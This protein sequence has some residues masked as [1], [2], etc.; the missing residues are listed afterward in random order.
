MKKL[1]Q[2]FKLKDLRMKIIAVALLLAASRVF[3]HI[4]I[5]GI[6]TAQLKEFFQQ[7]QLFGLL[8]I[9]AGG[10]L[11]NVS[12]AML[13]LAPYITASIIIQLLTI[14]IP[15]LQ[16][17]SKEGGE[18]GRA[19]I[20][21]YTRFL[22]IPLAVL[23]AF[24][25][26][27]LFSRGGGG[28][29]IIGVL[30]PFEWLLTLLSVTAG[31]MILM[32]LGEMITEYNIGNGISLLIFAGIVAQLPQFLSSA[33]LSFDSTQAPT[34]IGFGVIALL[35]I[36]G[37]VMITEATRNIPVSYAKRIRGNKLYGGV[38]THL[39]L[40][41]NTAG[42]IPIIFAISVLLFPGIVANFFVQANNAMI[43]GIAQKVV[44][45]FNNQTFY[46]A[47]YF[48]LVVLFTFFYTAVVFN[49]DE[50][51][52]N[53]QRQGGFV[54]GLRPGS[55]TADFLT[56]VLNRITLAGAVFLGLIAVLPFLFQAFTGSGNLVIGG[57]SLLIVVA[58]VIETVKQ[59]E[60]QLVAHDYEG[61]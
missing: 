21:Q 17:L 7:N 26:I 30:T 31:T 11:T 57:T 24:G 52:E 33:S 25:T 12:I 19:K 36:A 3:A 8:D 14:L 28:A 37:V 41:V 39:P 34:L 45:I 53:I 38:S 35:V 50:V 43:S 60:S 23:Q 59:I 44:E 40:R 58:V 13:G 15:K 47:A 2:I 4:P 1:I 46:G 18:A 51:S 6:D 22:T 56:K 29:G 49:P 27:M 54:P 48:L 20:N 16:E 32:W 42:V 61:F 55:Q 5:P 10:G 9:F